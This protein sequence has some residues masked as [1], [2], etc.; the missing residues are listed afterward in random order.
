MIINLF[1]VKCI[2]WFKLVWNNVDYKEKAVTIHKLSCES[3]QRRA[4]RLNHK[5]KW[6]KHPWRSCYDAVSPK[7]R[8]PPFRSVSYLLY[9]KWIGKKKLQSH[10]SNLCHWLDGTNIAQS[11]LL[12]LCK[13]N[14]SCRITCLG[15]VQAVDIPAG[16]PL[17]SPIVHH[18]LS[19]HRGGRRSRNLL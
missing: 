5:I 11:A 16:R 3:R 15:L 18:L 10:L 2:L 6:Q 8:C 4:T 7:T 14:Q 1:L 9:K 19:L 13:V 12:K 17:V